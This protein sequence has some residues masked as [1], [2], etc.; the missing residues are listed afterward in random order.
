MIS[1]QLILKRYYR[2]IISS[3]NAIVFFALTPCTA[4]R[5]KR[6]SDD[7][8]CYALFVKYHTIA[9]PIKINKNVYEVELS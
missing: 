4:E 7:A 3:D 1:R 8:T 6:A 9:A 5:V 2:K